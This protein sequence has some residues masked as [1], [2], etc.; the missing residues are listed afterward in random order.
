MN[1]RQ[2]NNFIKRGRN[3]RRRQ[4][5][6]VNVNRALDSNGPDVRIRGTATQIFEKYQALARDAASSGDRVKVENYLQHAEHYYRVIR[7]MTPAQTPNADQ[8]GEGEFEGDQ[9]SI[10]DYSDRRPFG[11]AGSE[12]SSG[13]DSDQDPPMRESQSGDY[14]PQSP[15]P[16]AN[17]TAE[18]GE[19]GGRDQRDQDQRHGRRRHRPRRPHRDGEPQGEDRGPNENRIGESTDETV[20]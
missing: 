20:S 1:G 12:P 2:G 15:E 14:R 9:P 10:S 8:G 7:A 18:Q 11:E 17:G 16:R 13:G 5:G 3:Q 6:G 19:A 4:G